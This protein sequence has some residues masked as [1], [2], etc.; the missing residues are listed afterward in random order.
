MVT[1]TKRWDWHGAGTPSRFKRAARGRRASTRGRARRETDLASARWAD[2]L[3]VG[4]VAAGVTDGQLATDTS[5]NSR[6]WAARPNC[7]WSCNSFLS[8]K[9]FCTLRPANEGGTETASL[10]GSSPSYD[11]SPRQ[12]QC[13]GLIQQLL[14]KE[15][16]WAMTSAIWRDHQPE[17]FRRASRHISLKATKLA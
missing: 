3:L 13:G 1:R 2:G 7:N 6:N 14:S 16:V 12:P 9:L 17:Q 11:V 10:E 5:R 4:K 15:A 8:R